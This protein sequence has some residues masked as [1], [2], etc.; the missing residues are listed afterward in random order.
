MNQDTAAEDEKAQQIMI[1]LANRFI[2]IANQMGMKEKQDPLLIG[3][4]LRY[5]AARYSAYESSRG[6][7][8]FLKDRDELENWFAS[9]FKTML[10]ANMQQEVEAL[11]NQ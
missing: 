6:S 8:D 5:A 2:S 11:K 1:D 7:K 9:Q 10:I 4:A 3:S